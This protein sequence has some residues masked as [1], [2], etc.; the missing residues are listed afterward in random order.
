MVSSDVL[1]QVT[2]LKLQPLE[3]MHARQPEQAAATYFHTAAVVR[4]VAGES[5]IVD[6]LAER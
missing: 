5:Q 1:G 3:P 4:E 6:R 2:E